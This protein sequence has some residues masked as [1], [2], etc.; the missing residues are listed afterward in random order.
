M[1]GLQGPGRKLYWDLFFW[2]LTKYPRKFALAIT[3][4]IYGHHF[5]M[6]NEQNGL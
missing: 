1:I 2:T 6:I 4:A 5:R 3:F